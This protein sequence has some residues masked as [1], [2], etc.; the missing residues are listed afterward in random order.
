MYNVYS[1]VKQ[2]CF[3]HSNFSQEFLMRTIS[4]VVLI[5]KHIV[6]MVKKCAALAQMIF[7]VVLLCYGAVV[8]R[9]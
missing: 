2:G 6:Y 7:L 9:L 8:I 1:I 5:E 3:S 4:C